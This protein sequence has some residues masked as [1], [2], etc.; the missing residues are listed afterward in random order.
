MLGSSTSRYDNSQV[1][2]RACAL[3][4]LF[5]PKFVVLVNADIIPCEGTPVFGGDLNYVPKTSAYT[6]RRLVFPPMSYYHV[7]FVS[8]T[9]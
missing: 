8:L 9:A 1:I 2:W 7:P 3:P 6:H 4:P 5:Y